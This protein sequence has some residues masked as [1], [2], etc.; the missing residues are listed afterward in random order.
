M[1][2][3][4]DEVALRKSI[5]VA[6]PLEH[7]FRVYTERMSDWYP[8]EGHSIFDEPEHDRLGGASRRASLRAHPPTARR[9]SGGR[10]SPGS[11]RAS[12]R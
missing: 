4:T 12:S 10:S 6:C 9:V 5:V 2:R 11:R 1:S 3:I 8:I 7:S